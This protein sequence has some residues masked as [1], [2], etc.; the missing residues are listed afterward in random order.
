MSPLSLGA[1]VLY[2]G[3]VF[4]TSVLLTAT[5]RRVALRRGW[6]ARPS[7]DRWHQVSTA[8]HGGVGIFVPFFIASL[9][10]VLGWPE[11]LRSATPPLSFPLAYAFLAGVL[12]M[13]LFGLL[14]DVYHFKPATKFVCQLL[15]ANA[16]IFAGGVLGVTGF[17]PVDLLLTYFWFIGITNALNMLDNMDGLEAGV[18]IIALVSTV[19]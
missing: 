3:L 14:D 6:V 5:M 13:F 16:F 2:I 1:T 12:G 8:L 18:A 17:L 11:E 4:G 19:F 10:F 15:A 9:I 7:A